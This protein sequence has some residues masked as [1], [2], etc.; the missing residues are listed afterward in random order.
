MN[1]FGRIFGSDGGL[2]DPS[3]LTADDIER[4]NRN[5]MAANGIGPTQKSTDDDGAA[6]AFDRGTTAKEDID[7]VNY[8]SK[9]PWLYDPHR[10]VR[11]DFDPIEL[12]NLAQENAWVQ[13]LIQSIGKEIAETSWTITTTDDPRETAKR[14]NTHP[15][16]RDP[17][18]K[19]LPDATAERIF[20]LLQNPNPDQTWHDIIEMWVAD[21]LEVG[22]S[23]AIK[24]FPSSAYGPDN[25]T[26]STDPSR[27][28]PRGLRVTAPEVWTKEY[29]G[30]TGLL[31]GFW[32]FEN[33]SSP[34]GQTRSRGLQDPIEFDTSEVMWNDHSPKSNR[35][36]GTPPT[37]AVSK[38]LKAINLA[39]VQE[40]EYLSRGSTPSGL[41]VTPDDK[42]AADERSSVMTE[43][44]KG[45][46]WKL[47][48]VQVGQNDTQPDFVPF[49][50]NF[51]E[52]QFTERQQWYAQ[53]IAAEFQVPTAVV[54][55]Q[56]EKINYNT[57]QG[58]RQN[59][60]ANTL[61]PYLQDFERWLTESFIKPHWDGY[62]FEFTP[63]MSESTRQL[64][65]DRVRAEWDANLRGRKEARKELGLSEDIGDDD[66]YKDDA[67]DGSG[68][69]EGLADVLG[70]SV[71]K[72]ALRNTDDYHVFDVQPSDVE[73]LTE[74]I[75]DDVTELFEEA[76]EDAELQS[77][78]ERLADDTDDTEK[79]VSA[80]A[81]R[82]REILD[83][84]DVADSIQ[85]ALSERTTAAALE[86][87]REASREAGA[88]DDVDIEA[89]ESQLQDRAVEFADDFAEEMAADIRET[90]AEG[91]A[92]GENSREI[93]EAIAEEADINE[94]WQGAEKIARQEL[95]IATGEAR[96]EVADDL[97][98]VEVWETAGDDR[99]RD[100]HAEMDGTWK[101]PND[102]W[103]VEYDD[104]G[105]KEES[106]Q[107][108]SEPGI[109]CR[110]VTLLVDRSEVDES[111]YAGNGEAAR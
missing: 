64:I 91:W 88:G 8:R 95:H 65:S 5:W 52:M 36:Y 26:L 69:D 104:R 70:Q 37:L 53:V 45:K 43:D 25:E 97:G 68:D 24:A 3:N 9:F 102:D 100:A 75:S 84:S 46:P 28:R 107:G 73:A 22:S 35:R 59:F 96:Q 58:E 109:G 47:L 33:V 72:E 44:V 111:D 81:R 7:G 67:V 40:Q 13:M 56:P 80:L 105:V 48:E 108:D 27:V 31:S 11:W 55:T 15:E 14:H 83:E 77:I 90:V 71:E 42:K 38:F 12:R 19:D 6:A 79:S 50:Y 49:S 4:L 29:Q 74:E 103:V 10:G 16:Q 18:A 17:V 99:V 21:Y 2:P 20:D 82:L 110:C 63:G 66:E 34:G 101:Y 94:G 54:G 93:S 61:G 60:E 30:K 76:L 62:R 86:A 39:V 98:K 51:D 1:P 23:V 87:A 57:F 106:V 92:E 89:I 85:T 78:I 32:Q 41:L